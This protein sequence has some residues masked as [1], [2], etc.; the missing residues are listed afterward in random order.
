MWVL[1]DVG[2]VLERICVGVCVGTE[3][4]GVYISSRST[5]AAQLYQEP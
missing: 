1:G 4:V 2:L 5:V 3:G